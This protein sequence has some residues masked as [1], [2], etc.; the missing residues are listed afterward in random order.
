MHTI[1]EMKQKWA[2]IWPNRIHHVIFPPTCFQLVHTNSKEVVI[3]IVGE[4]AKNAWAN[5]KKQKTR[6]PS[7]SLFNR[8]CTVDFYCEMGK[9]KESNIDASLSFQSSTRDA[10]LDKDK[11]AIPY[12]F[13]FYCLTFP[14]PGD[15]M[16]CLYITF[17]VSS[18]LSL[19][20][21]NVSPLFVAVY[22]RG[23]VAYH[24]VYRS[25]V[26]LS[27]D[28]YV[29]REWDKRSYIYDLFSFGISIDP[30]N[31]ICILAYLLAN[32]VKVTRCFLLRRHFCW[33]K[34]ERDWTQPWVIEM[35]IIKKFDYISDMI[36]KKV[37]R[38]NDRKKSYLEYEIWFVNLVNRICIRCTTLLPPFSYRWL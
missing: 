3:Y 33:P 36:N 6:W 14:L 35:H 13:L 15:S 21:S 24:F 32:K 12:P 4:P 37:D 30:R 38:K 18:C 11:M 20:M 2:K 10:T 5:R 9:F 16:L 19:T 28:R 34:K 29:Y 31:Y 22:W 23:D 27:K 8:A 17:L 25:S 26:V 7:V 1:N